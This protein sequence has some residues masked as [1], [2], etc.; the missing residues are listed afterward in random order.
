MS[1]YFLIP[2]GNPIRQTSS[3]IQRFGSNTDSFDSVVLKTPPLSSGKFY[4]FVNPQSDSTKIV[5]VGDSGDIVEIDTESLSEVVLSSLKQRDI[6]DVVLSPAGDSVVYSYYDSGT[7]R[8]WYLNFKKGVSYEMDENTKSVAFSPVGDRL[9]Y[10]INDEDGGEILISKEG[11]DIKH[12]LK[13]RLDATIIG[14]PSD[15][16]SFLSYDK[17]GYGDL[18]IFKDAGL[19]KILSYQ[20][21]LGVKWFSSGGRMIFSVKDKSNTDHLFYKDAFSGDKSFDLE[22]IANVSKCAWFDENNIICG[23]ENRPLLKD[24]F[25]K[26]ST[27]DGSRTLLSTP[28]INLLTKELVVSRSGNSVFVL[29]DIDDRIYVLIIN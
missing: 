12:V 5:A 24:E 11:V 10:L 6:S 19:K 1:A 4:S 25:Y 18:F 3:L 28:D 27:I 9:V 8:Y 2:E 21:D 13:T 29:N 16:L 15:F 22:I 20:Y 23:L 14:W 7:K 17:N 26:I